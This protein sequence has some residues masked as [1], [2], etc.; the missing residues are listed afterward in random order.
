MAENMYL[1]ALIHSHLL[2]CVYVY[3]YICMYVYMYICIHVYMYIP[4]KHV[5][6]RVVCLLRYLLALPVMVLSTLNSHTNITT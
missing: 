2:M 6:L 5:K 3:M 1:P 4:A